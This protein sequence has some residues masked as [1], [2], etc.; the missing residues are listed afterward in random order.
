VTNL[1][2]LDSGK[3]DS[4]FFHVKS[5]KEVTDPQGLTRQ[6]VCLGNE[7][8]PWLAFA[9]DYDPETGE[10]EHAPTLS[11]KLNDLDVEPKCCGGKVSLLKYVEGDRRPTSNSS[12]FVDLTEEDLDW[13][14]LSPDADGDYGTVEEHPEGSDRGGYVPTLSSGEHYDEGDGEWRD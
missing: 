3:K 8:T 13:L 7:Q 9:L 10:W 2:N 11:E 14:G 12:G 1:P 6:E 5:V 4:G